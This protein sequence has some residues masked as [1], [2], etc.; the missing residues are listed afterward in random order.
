V[1][2]T[3]RIVAPASAVW[4][5]VSA[6]GHLE[7]CHPFCEANPVL[8]WPGPDSRDE[9]HYLNGWVYERRFRGWIDGV[10]YD[11]DIGGRGEPTSHV[12]W[13]IEALG[14]DACDLTITIEPHLLQRIPVFVRWL[15]HVFSLRPRLRSYLSS[16]LRGIEWFVLHGEPVARNQFGRH[17]WFSEK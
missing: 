7:R 15:P 9:V 13:R 14:D 16:V 2:V 6:P 17:P 1:A 5:A 11:L 4:A 8:S 10:G 12:T 3:H